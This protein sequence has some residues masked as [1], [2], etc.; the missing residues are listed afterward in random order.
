MGHATAING[1]TNE[2]GS[3]SNADVLPNYIGGKWVQSK[4]Q[5]RLDV[6]NPATGELLVKT[7]LSTA[8][9]VDAAVAAATAAFPGWSETPVVQRARYLFKFKMLLEEPSRRSRGW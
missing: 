7:P 9:D 3:A 8:A 5:E 4:G 6:R 2:T 1:V